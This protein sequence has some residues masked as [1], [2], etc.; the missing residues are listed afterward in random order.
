MSI[1]ADSMTAFILQAIL[2]YLPALIIE[3]FK[4]GPA[5]AVYF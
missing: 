5:P 2:R 3:S 1:L 4:L